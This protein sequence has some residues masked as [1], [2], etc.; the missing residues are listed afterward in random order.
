MYYQCAVLGRQ[1][2]LCAKQRAWR[3]VT[4]T[5]D[6]AYMTP[7]AAALPLL[8]VAPLHLH[9]NGLLHI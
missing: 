5:C 6:A 2:Y 9:C 1:T 3:Y 8:P 7:R 4:R